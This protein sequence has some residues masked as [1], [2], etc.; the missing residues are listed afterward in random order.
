MRKIVI[1]TLAWVAL[2]G[3]TITVEPGWK[4][5]G[6]TGP[7]ADLGIFEAECVSQV[8]AFDGAWRRY[9]PQGEQTLD[10]I[11]GGQGFWIEGIK[12]C[13][14]ETE[15]ATQSTPIAVQAGWQ[16]VG[17]PAAITDPAFF[18]PECVAGV[19]TRTEAG[20]QQY[21]PAGT[22]PFTPI[23]AGEGFWIV[24]YQACTLS[25]E[26]N[27]SVRDYADFSLE[28][29]TL[30][31]QSAVNLSVTHAEPLDVIVIGDVPETFGQTAVYITAAQT[32]R[33]ASEGYLQPLPATGETGVSMVVPALPDGEYT[34]R[35]TDGTY[36]TEGVTLTIDALPEAQQDYTQTLYA[37][38]KAYVDAAAKDQGSSYEALKAMEN[39]PT[40][41][42]PLYAA[43]TVLEGD[44]DGAPQTLGTIHETNATAADWVNRLIEKSGLAALLQ[45]ATAEANAFEADSDLT[46]ETALAA[47]RATPECTDVGKPTRTIADAQELSRLMQHPLTRK[48]D[49][50]LN[51]TAADTWSAIGAA[52]KIGKLPGIAAFV[53][54]ALFVVQNVNDFIASLYPSEL[55]YFE[56]SV[57]SPL[58]EDRPDSRPGEATGL[59]V[60]A[61]SQAFNVT[62]V[63]VE[64]AVQ[65]ASLIPVV[66]W[67]IGATTYAFDKQVKQAYKKAGEE[68]CYRIAPR[69][70]GPYALPTP[71]IDWLKTV[72]LSGES[73]RL[74]YPHTFEPLEYAPQTQV[75]TG[76]LY[77]LLEPAKFGGG[78]MGMQHP[79][80]V[81]EKT[82][83]ASPG[84]VTVAKRAGEARFNV[85]VYADEPEP[86][87][88]SAQP[89]VGVILDHHYQGNGVHEVIV[90]TSETTIFP[91]EVTVA[92]TSKQLLPQGQRSTSVTVAL[93]KPSI[94]IEAMSSCIQPGTSVTLQ[95]V[96]EG[97][98][99]DAEVI[100]DVDGGTITPLADDA[101][102]WQTPATQGSFTVTA[103]IT[104]GGEEATDSQQIV[105][106]NQCL[107]QMVAV[108]LEG[109]LD[110]DPDCDEWQYDRGEDAYHRETYQ[111]PDRNYYPNG[112]GYPSSYLYDTGFNLAISDFF[113]SS[114]YSFDGSGN[115]VCLQNAGSIAAIFN[116]EVK[117]SGAFAWESDLAMDQ[118]CKVDG[119]GELVCVD[120]FLTM[121]AQHYF[122]MPVESETTFEF[123]LT[124]ACDSPFQTQ[125]VN[126]VFFR[127]RQGSTEPEMSLNGLDENGAPIPPF[128]IP[129]QSWTLEC[130]GI[131]A[132]VTQSIELPMQAPT[133]GQTDTLLVATT[134]ASAPAEIDLEA[135]EDLLPKA[136]DNHTRYRFNGEVSLQRK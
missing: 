132:P 113:T 30:L 70:W 84:Y 7:I 25:A 27:E 48:G 23:N 54:P 44:Y 18:A 91:I 51:Q 127:Y 69:E 50:T 128:I 67:E 112:D 72:Q 22:T 85:A 39:P 65:G 81:K 102:R 76:M 5:V 77:L 53:G 20:W 125:L 45:A 32:A 4:L 111:D 130:K 97:Y 24:G 93:E 116:G 3:Q 124:G 49:L 60:S 52:D 17:A 31:P 83:S 98:R 88:V 38:L 34:L 75:G 35:L 107:K 16:L 1:M 64:G 108:L 74:L 101:A 15:A 92:S 2:W 95:A 41:L 6:A 131:G 133:D 106:S 114:T 57:E 100:W 129:I 135:W 28:E 62:E 73:V 26:T 43:I 55:S 11:A 110:G 115:D 14:V 13:I 9:A 40:A 33:E 80:V 42:L 56:F 61:K 47:A 21:E 46:F 78:T 66:G 94:E 105:L 123:T 19:Y 89:N 87:T 126:V 99:A 103:R 12:G 122:Y 86:I 71:S 117:S 29:V 121:V 120:T 134:I 119:D 109:E 118:S 37:D 136:G 63:A 8:L 59:M 90:T 104:A 10:A 79:I 82:L 36:V 96:V 68:I 58:Y